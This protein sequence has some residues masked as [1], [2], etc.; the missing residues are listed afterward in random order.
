MRTGGGIDPIEAVK[1]FE[2]FKEF[3][4]FAPILQ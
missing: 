2:G 3:E 4:E 1:E